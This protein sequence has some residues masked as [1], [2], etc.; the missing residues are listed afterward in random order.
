[1]MWKDLLYEIPAFLLQSVRDV[2]SEHEEQA[3]YEETVVSI[4]KATLAMCEAKVQDNVI[5]AML[6]K[7][8]DLR[9]SEAREFLSGAKKHLGKK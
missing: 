8:W 1:M 7:Y 6:Q 2:V 4:E 3:V 5:I 9:L